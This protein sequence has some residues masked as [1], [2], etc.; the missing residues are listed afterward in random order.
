VPDE[1]PSKS[2]LKKRGL[3]EVDHEEPKSSKK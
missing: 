2:L 1:K 3:S